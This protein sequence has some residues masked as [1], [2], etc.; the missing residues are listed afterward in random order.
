MSL[1]H[2]D[3][4]SAPAAP[5]G[6]LEVADLSAGQLERL[7]DL[8]GRQRDEPEAYLDALR[9]QSVACLFEKPSTRTRVSLQAAAH[10][11]G[12]LPILLRPDELQLDRGEP[13]E[14]T[15]RV[16]SGYTGG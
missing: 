15:A 2:A 11:L 8:A 3:E 12:L 1:I 7:L 14:D 13:L 10:R 16:L 4:T 9:G 6:L 5:A